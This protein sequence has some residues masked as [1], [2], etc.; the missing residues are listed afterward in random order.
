MADRKR[1]RKC[2][3]GGSDL[4]V[5]YTA[6]AFS[7][8]PCRTG[9][10][11][12]KA[13]Q[14]Q[15]P[16]TIHVALM[17]TWEAPPHVLEL[18]PGAAHV[19]LVERP[20]H[21]DHHRLERLLGPEERRRADEFAT[22]DLRARYL[23]AH[24]LLRLLLARYLSRPPQGISLE[25]AAAGKPRLRDGALHF[26]LAHTD[27]RLL[28]A[29]SRDHP[30]GVDIERVRMRDNYLAIARRMFA[31]EE[32]AALLDTPETL[33]QEAFFACWT[34]K[35]AYVKARG[36]GLRLSLESFTV[37]VGPLSDSA[38]PVNRPGEPPWFLLR[39]PTHA[40]YQLA[41]AADA[42]LTARFW[43]IESNSERFFAENH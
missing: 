36:L 10:R 41:L 3:I 25:A 14:E 22:A 32:Y 24:G 8:R 42:A 4:R 37:P 13:Q 35:E 21:A 20:E 33:R 7:Q 30:V 18:P 6:A 29:I 5:W 23:E 39:L 34:R 11:N 31:P 15:R 1:R 12:D 16:H 17:E 2:I 9:S 19:W 38:T 27:G 40:G 43:R 28:Y 26:N